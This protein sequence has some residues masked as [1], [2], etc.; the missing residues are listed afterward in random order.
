MLNT[1][2]KAASA[3]IPGEAKKVVI[4]VGGQSPAAFSQAS[5]PAR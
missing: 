2:P 3:R 4:G 5:Y 1:M